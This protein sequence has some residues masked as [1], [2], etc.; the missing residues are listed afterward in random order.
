M[1][2]VV[3]LDINSVKNQADIILIGN[4]EIVVQPNE[5][6]GKKRFYENGILGNIFYEIKAIEVLKGHLPAKSF[7]LVRTNVNSSEGKAPSV[8]SLPYLLFLHKVELDKDAVLQD[9]VFYGLV[10]N[11]KGIISLDG[12]ALE[13]RAVDRIVKQY[14]INIRERQEDFKAAMRYSL[15]EQGTKMPKKD[16][17]PGAFAVYEGL[18][19]IEDVSQQITNQIVTGVLQI[20]GAGKTNDLGTVG[21]KSSG[22]S[23]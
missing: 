18:K 17:N 14:G 5:V 10:G 21:Y 7:L 23:D 12:T 1:N 2:N 11:W 19:L 4:L 15:K 8:E 20:P 22:N 9:L 13:C 16:L 6:I 3:S